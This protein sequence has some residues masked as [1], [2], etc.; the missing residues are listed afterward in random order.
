MVPGIP[1][2]VIA[3]PLPAAD[4]IEISDL[5]A[6]LSHA[7]D[8]SRPG[9]VVALFTADG[10]YAAQTS[11]ADGRRDRFR[12]AGADSVREF[13][14]AAAA[15]RQGLG[16]HWVGNPLI[17]ADGPDRARATSYVL[18]VEIDPATGERRIPLS[19]VHHDTFVRTGAGWR[20]ASRTI[21]ADI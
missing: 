17:E 11:E 9:D 18:F 16:R 4:H 8:F 14:A 10:T 13:A 7:L 21:V 15:R 3:M 5:I 1:R 2:E 12:H 20:F 19:G 6:R